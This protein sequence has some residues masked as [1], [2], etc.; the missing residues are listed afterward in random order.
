MATNGDFYR[1]GPLRVYGQAVGEGVAWPRAQTGT[2]P[3]YMDEW[4]WQDI[5]STIEMLTDTLTHTP[6]DYGFTYQSSW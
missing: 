4:Y 6:E 5:D 1:T 3:A 2:D